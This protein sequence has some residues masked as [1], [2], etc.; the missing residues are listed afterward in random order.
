MTYWY[1]CSLST[2]SPRERKDTESLVSPENKSDYDLIGGAPAVTAVVDAFY[3]KVLAD[4]D[5]TEFFTD[6][7]LPRLKRHQVMLV[8]HVLGGPVNYEGRALSDAHAHLPIE[9]THF[10][11]VVAHL[12]DVLDKAGVGEEIIGRVGAVLQDSESEIVSVKSS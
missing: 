5:L 7:D 4:P 12:V 8:S 9:Q 6:V 10:R 3:Q 2:V 1:Q 11:R